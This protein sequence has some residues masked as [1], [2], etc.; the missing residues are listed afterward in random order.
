MK[1]K[2]LGGARVFNGKK[3]KSEKN[4]IYLRNPSIIS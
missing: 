3:K 4:G 1:Y 2:T